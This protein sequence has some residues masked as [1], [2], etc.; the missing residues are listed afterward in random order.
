VVHVSTVDVITGVK[1][2]NGNQPHATNAVREVT[3][4]NS[5]TES[6]HIQRKKTEKTTEDLKIA[7]N[8]LLEAIA[9]PLTRTQK[10]NI[11]KKES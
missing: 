10:V 3:Y 8:P 11:R 6:C 1:I 7:I 4:K 5:V 9:S 2:A